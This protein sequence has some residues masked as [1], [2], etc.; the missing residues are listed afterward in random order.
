MSRAT[1]RARSAPRVAALLAALLAGCSAVNGEPAEVPTCRVVQSGA[2]LPLVLEESSGVAVSRAHRGV[3][4]THNDSGGAP[5]LF[6]VDADGRL[7]GRVNVTGATN[8]DWEDL[9][10]GPCPEGTCVY[11]GDFGDNDA[12]RDEVSLYRVPE[13]SPE[14]AASAR[15]A[16]FDFRYPDG[17]RDA[18]SLFVLPDGEVYVLT[19]GRAEP[20]SLYRF[21]QPLRAGRVVVLEHVRDLSSGAVARADQVTGAD[22]SPDGRWIAV[23]TYAELLLYPTDALLRGRDPQPVR[24]DLTPLA[25]PQG[26]G[27]G[28]G[29]EG[30]V[31]LSSEGGGSD[32]PGQLAVLSCAEV[33]GADEED[34]APTAAPATSP[35]AGSPSGSDPRG[36]PRR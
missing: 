29:A 6:A 17:P 8:F 21:P 36:A 12:V 5:E 4:W 22:A 11:V 35:S 34:A 3:L 24:V 18:E 13:P 1:R 31:V 20:I 23:R 28:F 10:L 30:A 7:L 16:R 25:E 27:V 19:K 15:A 9:A 14:A 33:I 2:L 26:E 32:L